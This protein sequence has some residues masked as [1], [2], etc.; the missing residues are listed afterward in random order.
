MLQH[1]NIFLFGK[2][3]GVFLRRTIRKEAKRL[4]IPGFVENKKDGS[5]YIEIE[6]S[7]AILEQFVLWLKS[8]AGKGDYEI[9]RVEVDKGEFKAFS[10]EFEIN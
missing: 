3:Q 5:V 8:G 9:K 1:L 4:G 7:E 6:G 2:V 10:G